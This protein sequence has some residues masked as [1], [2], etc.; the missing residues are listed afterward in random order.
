[1]SAPPPRAAT[2]TAQTRTLRA[3]AAASSG[4]FSDALTSLLEDDRALAERLIGPA[5]QATD[6]VAFEI[7]AEAGRR[8]G[9]HAVIEEILIT[10]SGIS[11][12]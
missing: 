8:D 5:R 1:M 6:P 3:T 2:T 4:R 7:S 10:L 12:R 11:P 9:M